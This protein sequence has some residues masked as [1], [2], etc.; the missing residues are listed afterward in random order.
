[1]KN[2]AARRVLIGL[3]C[4]SLCV[5]GFASAYNGNPRLIVVI[6]IDQFRGDLLERHRDHFGP[7]G[8]R[9]FLDR[10]AVFTNCHYDY[11]NTRTAPGHAT[12]FTGTYTNG[13]GIAGNEWWDPAS[14]AVVTSVEDRETRIVAPSGLGGV[15]AS[16]R[17]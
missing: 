14:K 16:P 8:F 2:P 11:A 9:L 10:G 3:T 6:I 13:H 7:G 5:S 15:G 12:L 17:R 1:M 4:L